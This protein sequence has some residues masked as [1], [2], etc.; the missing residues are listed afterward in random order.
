M[1]TPGERKEEVSDFKAE[2]KVKEREEER[3]PEEPEVERRRRRR[4]SGR[5]SQSGECT[6]PRPSSFYPGT[7]LLFRRRLSEFG[8]PAE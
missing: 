7:K 5:A 2:C 3:K 8:K 4:R 1:A 6:S